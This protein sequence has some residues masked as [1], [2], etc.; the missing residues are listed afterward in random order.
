MPRRPISFFAL[1]L[2]LTFAAAASAADQEEPIVIY[3][4]GSEPQ[5]A[6]SPVRWD[7]SLAYLGAVCVDSATKTVTA[8]GWV[9]QTD[10]AIELFACGPKGKVHE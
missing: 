8:T 2:M 7:G 5:P 9:N 6:P 4:A 1:G 10:G 3:P